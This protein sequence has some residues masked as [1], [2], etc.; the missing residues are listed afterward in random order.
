MM[1]VAEWLKSQ[2][3]AFPEPD[4]AD[5]STSFAA[6]EAARLPMVVACTGCTMT[7]ALTPE[8]PCDHDGRLYCSVECLGEDGSNLEPERHRMI[9]AAVYHHPECAAVETD[10]VRP[11]NCGFA[12]EEPE[13]AA[14]TSPWVICGLCRGEGTHVNPA[15]DSH[16]LTREDFDDDPDFAESYFAGHYDV[17]CVRCSGTGKIREAAQAAA[18][19]KAHEHAERR[20]EAAREDGD[21][22]GYYGASDERWG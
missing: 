17:P 7:F 16:G 18:I 4:G 19:D 1:T 22:E 9:G 13:P 2:G 14:D 5:G 10:G 11:C 12:D 8:R 3:R 20:R 6:Y 21:A 15:I